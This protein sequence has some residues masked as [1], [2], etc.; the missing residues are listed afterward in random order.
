MSKTYPILSIH[1]KN[2]FH[3]YSLIKKITG[4]Q[5]KT[6][7]PVKANAYGCG[8]EEIMP[9]FLDAL[10]DFLGVANPHEG[11]RIRAAGWKGNI[12]NLGGFFADDA[13]GFIESKI[14]PCLTDL[15]QIDCL[16]KTGRQSQYTFK[17]HIKLD[18]GMGRIGILPE[19]ISRLIAL[20]K[21]SKNIEISG[22]FTHFPSA[23]NPTAPSNKIILQRLEESVKLII[24]GLKLE[25]SDVIVHSAN[26]AALMLNPQ[27]HLDMVRPGLCFYGYFP[28]SRDRK[29]LEAEFP[30][31][32]ALE[33]SVKPISIRKLSQNATISYG[34]TFTIQEENYPVGVIP[35][36]YGDGI[37]RALSNRISFNGHPLLGRVTMDQIILGGIDSLDQSITLLGKDALPMESWADLDQT[38]SYEIMVRLGDRL[39]RVLV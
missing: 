8:I 21:E 7:I 28:N 30:F 25:R 24:E 5:V 1:K 3:N 37:P 26:S 12:L 10:P 31:Q 39:K 16:N 14:T 35:L 2:L 15:W 20:L 19:D 38:I 22:I 34:E 9:F 32:A 27:S 11:K 17:P 13:Y 33:L 29:A 4:P 36:G 23:D 18:L 6:L